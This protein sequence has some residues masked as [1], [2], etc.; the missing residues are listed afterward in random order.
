MQYFTEHQ[1]SVYMISCTTEVQNFLKFLNF[2]TVFSQCHSITH[3][4]L[5]V[6]VWRFDAFWFVTL[7]SRLT[8]FPHSKGIYHLHCQGL[9]CHRSSYYF[10]DCTELWI[11]SLCLFMWVNLANPRPHVSQTWGFSPVCMRMCTISVFRRL[12]ALPQW[13]HG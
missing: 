10:L 3:T 2:N 6:I 7:I 12:N 11:F 13:V 4:S 9:R 8:Y 1:A 5:A